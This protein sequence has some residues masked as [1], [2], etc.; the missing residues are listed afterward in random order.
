MRFPSG[1]GGNITDQ[2]GYFEA[3]VCSLRDWLLGVLDPAWSASPR[4]WRNVEDALAALVQSPRVT[5]RALIPVG[6]WTMMLSNGPLGTDVGV[7]PSA[8]AR[9]LNCRALRAVSTSD[10]ERYPARILEVFGPGGRPPSLSV[11]SIAAANDGGRWIFETPGE[12]FSFERQDAYTRRLKRE[13]FSASL[14]SDYLDHLGVPA[15]SEPGWAE[16]W[17]LERPPYSLP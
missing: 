6:G 8:A 2:V 15:A 12:P 16:T 17:L 3:P 11:R 5:R 10:A 4:G 14:L 7:L 9:A 13:R 1:L